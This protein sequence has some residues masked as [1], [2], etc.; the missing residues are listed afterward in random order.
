MT[1]GGRN[2]NSVQHRGGE[3]RGRGAVKESRR[4]MV[5]SLVFIRGAAEI[6]ALQLTRGISERK[7][8]QRLSTSARVHARCI[9]ECARIRCQGIFHPSRMRTPEVYFP[10][11][12][13][14]TCDFFCQEPGKSASSFLSIFFFFFF[15]IE[16][17]IRNG[18]VNYWDLR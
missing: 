9:V 4:E 2:Q 15:L 16:K 14:L 11:R 13:T 3:G 6:S 17:D 12:G 18:K 7:I 8:F 1:S 5:L 10:G